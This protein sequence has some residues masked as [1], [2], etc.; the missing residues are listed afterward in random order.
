MGGNMKLGLW[1]ARMDNSGLGQQTYGFYKYMRPAKTVVIDISVL[2]RL[3]KRVMRQYPERYPDATIISGIPNTGDIE[4]FLQGLD[5]VFIAESSYNMDFYRLAR[6]YGVKV[7]VQYNYE[8]FDWY[9]MPQCVPDMLIA[10]STWH[11][12]Q[13]ADFCRDKGVKHLYLHV[14]VDTE[15]IRRRYI[16]SAH[17]FVHIAGRP[18]AHDRNGTFTFLEA[19]K[20]SN[21][22]LNGTV[23]TQD[24]DLC[25]RINTEYPRVKVKYNVGSY[26]EIYKKGSV[27]VLP[28]KYGGNC[29]PL[30]EALAAGMPVIMSKLQPQDE[31][32][33]RRW[34]VEVQP[35]DIHFAP[36]F[37][38]PVYECDPTALLFR[39][40][41]FKSL[42]NKDMAAQSL[43]ADELADSI[44]WHTMQP[45]YQEVLEALC[46]L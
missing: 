14:P 9:Q 18:A 27:L 11:Y 37:P 42:S 41:W 33:P 36:R 45:K 8:F 34:L 38:I 17:S 16:D 43:I 29:L 12:H 19:L 32:L 2:E 25:N 24:K 5:V 30:N 23:Y 15:V 4:Q 46:K 10:P 39:M 6:N 26:N 40:R 35:T 3:P 22:D 7:A 13:V 21:G 20:Q 44:S 31:F 28:R 1:G